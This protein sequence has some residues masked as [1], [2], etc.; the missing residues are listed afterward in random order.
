MKEIL[1]KCNEISAGNKEAKRLLVKKHMQ[2]PEFARF[3]TYCLDDSLTFGVSRVNAAADPIEGDFYAKL[4]YLNAKGSASKEDKED[5]ARL[6]SQSPEH[7][8]VLNKILRKS[9][10]C[11]FTAK[12]LNEVLPGVV[13][14]FPY[15]RCSTH[16]K[17]DKIF[18]KASD[19]Y[20]FSDLKENGQFIRVRLVPGMPPVFETRNGKQLDFSYALDD[21]FLAIDPGILDVNGVD[22]SV[23]DHGFV[24][25][26]EIL[27]LAEDGTG[28]LPRA[29][30]NALINQ[31]QGGYGSDEVLARLRFSFWNV[32]P[33]VHYVVGFSPLTME[34][35]R[36]CVAQLMDDNG[37][38]HHTETKTI[39]SKEEAYDHYYEVR[40]R[41]TLDPDVQME[42]TIVKHPDEVWKDGTS[43]LMAKLKSEKQCELLITGWTYGKPGGRNEHRLGS[44]IC[45]SSCGRL[46]AKCSGMSDAIRDEDPETHVGK[47]C[48]G[49]YN[50]V[51]K[52]KDV[53]KLRSLDHFRFDDFR[54]DKTVADDLEYILKVKSKRT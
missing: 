52:S 13:P 9:P 54:P 17:L 31:F 19:G 49:T 23:F 48:T 16:D 29:I 6:G 26:G 38:M 27:V 8:V 5:L 39:F 42:G 3:F 44:F 35:R 4:D 43:S 32:V 53:N 34:Q 15:Q 18:D 28:H 45:Q 30:G 20:V 11:G 22:P 10:D 40:S 41:P 25:E 1:R 7:L 37:T 14:Y 12:S 21:P 2:D 50:E 24:L 47:I 36:E 46:V 33:Y 51:S